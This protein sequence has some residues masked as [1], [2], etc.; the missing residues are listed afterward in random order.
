M[1]H[2]NINYY[3]AL[4]KVSKTHDTYNG[5]SSDTNAG[6]GLFASPGD[7]LVE[8]SCALISNEGKRLWK[9]IQ[10]KCNITKNTL[11]NC[12]CIADDKQAFSGTLDECISFFK[13]DKGS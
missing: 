2:E 9:Y 6:R 5:R 4:I 3:D 13:D 10:F 11:Y 12:V 8:Y 1:K 7:H